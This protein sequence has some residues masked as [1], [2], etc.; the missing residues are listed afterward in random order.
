MN[1][2]SR[3]RPT[4]FTLAQQA[5][6]E[7]FR[8]ARPADTILQTLFR[9]R[10]QMGS[11]DR[12][13][14]SELVYGVL[15]DLR[16]LK[17]MAGAEPAALGAAWLLRA[18][19]TAETLT[20]LGYE[21]SAAL[22]SRIAQFDDAS[23]SEAERLNLPDWLHAS[24]T[25]QY[26]HDEVQALGSALNQPA[27]SDLRVNTLRF[28]REQ[29]RAQLASEGIQSDLTQLSPIGLRLQKRAPLQ[30]THA[31]R[32]GWV[33]PQDEGS[34]LLALLVAPKPGDTVVDYCAG[35]GGKTL[36]LGALM[37]NQGRLFAF[38]VSES[39]LAKLGPREKRA[40]LRIVHTHV[41]RGE[42]DERARRLDNE[43]DAVLVDAP[44]S[45]TG[46]LRRNPELRLRTPDL[47]ALKAR[48][49]SIL[50]AAA[51]LVRPGGTLVYATCSFAAEENEQVMESFLTSHA[52]FSVD[53]AG[54]VLRA[55]GVAYEG[56]LLKLLPHRHGTDGFFAVRL[57]R[58]R[59]MHG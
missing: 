56:A 24:L 52:D 14:V 27:T 31:F 23:L 25:A 35:A 29:A 41:L 42:Q 1:A 55:Q 45:S 46:A 18:G 38:D 20:A 4:H 33:E 59:T 37:Q 32:E 2:V 17:A 22:V 12:A 15:R 19:S 51:Q 47:S 40:D 26:A 7:I 6:A 58:S 8:L 5:L 10:P 9:E 44:C 54:A 11:R 13:G 28:T 57:S 34:Q 43:C 16:R 39:R 30:G 48:Q 50:D 3:L 49:I 53:D 21:D 36:A